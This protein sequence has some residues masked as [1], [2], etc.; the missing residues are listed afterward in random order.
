MRTYEEFRR[1]L[2]DVFK[3]DDVRG[4]WGPKLDADV[5]WHLGCAFATTLKSSPESRPRIVVGCDMRMGSPLILAQLIQGIQA[6]GG[7]VDNLGM[8]G[9]EVIYYATGQYAKRYQGGAMVTASHNPPED[10]GVKFV[11]AGAKPLTPGELAAL[12]NETARSYGRY[13]NAALPGPERSSMTAEFAEKLLEIAGILRPESDEVPLTVVVEAGN[14]MGGETFGLVAEHLRKLLPGIEFRFSNETPDGS[15]PVGTPDPLLEKYKALLCAAVLKEEADLGI[16]FD[17]DADR[18][19]FM[20]EKG[21]TIGPS[22]VSTILLQ[23]LAKKHPDR[24]YV[25]GN[26][27]TSLQFTHYVK[28][29]KQSG[30][31]Q[32][33]FVMTPVGHAKIKGLMRSPTYSDEQSGKSKVLFASEHSGH[34]FYPDF[35]YADSGMTTALLMIQ[36]A[37]QVKAAGDGLSSDL[38]KWRGKYFASGEMNEKLESDRKAV[39]KIKEAAREYLPGTKRVWCGIVEGSVPGTHKVEEFQ[40]PVPYNP[41]S[42]AALDLRLDSA[43]GESPRWWF[44]LRKSGNEPKLRL[45]VESDD[46]TTMKE[47]RDKLLGIMRS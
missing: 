26:L 7:E 40:A 21:E 15:L 17:G 6:A 5:A 2:H 39:E 42:L 11:K 10:A 24:Q 18:A 25:M 29:S 38:A 35:F 44:S 12:K 28:Q 30:E 4:K 46:E 16:C 43:L 37:R 9:T 13:L 36:K 31:W 20:D 22:L 33:E 3:R 41:D 23:T 34:Y 1:V 47:L 45:N 8:C 19:G 14:G 32:C 27:N